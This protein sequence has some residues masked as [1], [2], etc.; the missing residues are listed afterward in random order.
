MIKVAGHR[1][2]ED[3][4]NKSQVDGKDI[5]HILHNISVS[6][7]SLFSPRKRNAFNKLSEVFNSLFV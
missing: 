6:A 3:E 1:G 4:T 7:S 2:R 5:L